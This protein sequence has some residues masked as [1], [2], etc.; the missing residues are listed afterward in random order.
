MLEGR[1]I[2]IGVGAV[3]AVS[4]SFVNKLINV[5]RGKEPPG[6]MLDETLQDAGIA[7]LGVSLMFDR[8][9]PQRIYLML[10]FVVLFGSNVIRRMWAYRRERAENQE[11]E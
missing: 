9:T 2:W 11:R 3:L 5:R 4:V 1:W 7:C 8:G 10:G 6:A